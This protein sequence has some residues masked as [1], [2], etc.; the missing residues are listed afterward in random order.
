MAYRLAHW[1]E[2][3]KCKRCF[4]TMPD[5]ERVWYSIHGFRDLQTVDGIKPYARIRREGDTTMDLGLYPVKA[6]VF[7]TPTGE[8]VK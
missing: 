7:E 5:G 3:Q 8:L 6:L 4:A 1:Q 2:I